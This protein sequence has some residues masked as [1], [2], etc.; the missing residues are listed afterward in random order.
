[1]IVIHP[2]DKTTAFLSAIYDGLDCK[3][4]DCNDSKKNIRSIIYNAPKGERVLLLGHGSSDGLFMR[5]DDTKDEFSLLIDRSFRY[6]LNKHNGNIIGIW[7]HAD[8]FAEREGLHGLFTGMIVSEMKEA[9]LYGIE[10][11]QEEL[12]DENMK[13][14][15]RLRRLFND[16]IPLIGIPDRIKLLDDVHSNLTKFNYNNINYV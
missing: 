13:L 4:I 7:C 5:D 1:M 2:K 14:A 8:E 15:L 16:G 6:V 12:D 3:V 10:T 11:T 9:A